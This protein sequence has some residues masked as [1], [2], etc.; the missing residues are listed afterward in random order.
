MMKEKFQFTSNLDGKCVINYGCAWDNESV[1]ILLNGVVINSTTNI[2][3]IEYE[4]DVLTNDVISIFESASVIRYSI[5]LQ[6]SISP[7]N[8][9]STDIT[10]YD[11]NLFTNK[12]F[13]TND[14]DSSDSHKTNSN[15]NSIGNIVGLVASNARYEGLDYWALDSSDGTVVV[16]AM[17]NSYV[18][19]VKIDINGNTI[20]DPI[21]NRYNSD[22]SAISS[23][24]DLI[25]RWTNGTSQPSKLYF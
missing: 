11:Y 4:F 25:E 10:T 2:G 22:L 18:R 19:M 12:Q 7:I 3:P 15:T 17:D 1:K 21:T 14:Q 23:K 8:Y 13:S 5:S 6:G 20:S 9:W 24:A 16:A